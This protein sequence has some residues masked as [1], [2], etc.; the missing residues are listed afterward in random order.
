MVDIVEP[1]VVTRVGTDITEDAMKVHNR[2]L[3]QSAKRGQFETVLADDEI[4][5]PR[6]GLPTNELLKL[7]SLGDVDL[8]GILDEGELRYNNSTA[9]W[10]VT[11]PDRVIM[12]A[13]IDNSQTISNTAAET[14]FDKNLAVAAGVLAATGRKIR[15]T[16]GGHGKH[17][18]NDGVVV[19]VKFGGV[20][21]WVSGSS[22]GKG[23]NDTDIA[24]GVTIEGVM[25]SPTT[26]A[27]HQL[28]AFSENDLLT[29]PVFSSPVTVGTGVVALTVTADWDDADVNNQIQ[30]T[31]LSYEIFQPNANQG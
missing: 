10:E 14:E 25:R 22:D 2:D 29:P 26:M 1:V 16:L 21:L 19:R 30:M 28:M 12:K 6:A 4:L 7:T 9:K 20:V 8:S 3:G 18:A 27:V 31:H 5:I 13:I 15:I 24:W 17:K 23:P 11:F